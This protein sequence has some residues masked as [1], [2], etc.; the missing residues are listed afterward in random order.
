MEMCQN[1]LLGHHEFHIVSFGLAKEGCTMRTFQTIPLGIWL[2][3]RIPFGIRFFQSIP[4]GIWLLQ[5]FPFG[6]WLL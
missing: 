1:G 4:L 3:Q 2:F 5:P 6:I